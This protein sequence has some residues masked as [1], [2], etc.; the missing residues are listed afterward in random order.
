MVNIAFSRFV[1]IGGRQWEVNFRKL[2]SE[3]NRFRA[4]TPTLD[5]DRI[6]FFLYKDH[7]SWHVSGNGVPE[8][9]TNAGPTLGS[10][11]EQTLVERFPH[12]VVG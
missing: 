7:S 9:I 10:V 11:V 12:A 3:N 8:W 6:E 4:D 1:K 2:P 5:G